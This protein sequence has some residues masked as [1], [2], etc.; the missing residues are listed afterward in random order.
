[1]PLK[2][3]RATQSWPGHKV[4][5]LMD[6]PFLWSFADGIKLKDELDSVELEKIR[7]VCGEQCRTMWT[8]IASR[9]RLY[10]YIALSNDTTQA[11]MQRRLKDVHVDERARFIEKTDSQTEGQVMTSEESMSRGTKRS[12]E[13]LGCEFIKK[14]HQENH[15]VPWPA[16]SSPEEL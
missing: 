9:E 14:I 8:T 13:L 15:F 4:I 1:M 7:L 12:V 6:E 5:F 3:L 11:E 2:L 10:Q 16:L